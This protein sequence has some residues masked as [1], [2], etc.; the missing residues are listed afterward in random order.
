MIVILSCH[1]LKDCNTALLMVDHTWGHF[2]F[3]CLAA[4]R[5]ASS[6]PFHLMRNMSSPEL[7]VAPMMRSACRPRSNPR[8][9]IGKH[10]L[11]GS[12]QFWT[13]NLPHILSWMKLLCSRFPILCSNTLSLALLL[14]H[15]NFV[16]KSFDQL[17]TVKILFWLP[18]VFLWT[19]SLKY[20]WSKH[21]E[22]CSDWL[23]TF[24]DR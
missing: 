24:H 20:E 15:L 9:L 4:T 13:V 21:K 11:S 12:S 14:S 8:G 2:M 6:L 22:K 17:W 23:L 16:L 1:W 18:C 19:K 10:S 5:S 3:A 7:S